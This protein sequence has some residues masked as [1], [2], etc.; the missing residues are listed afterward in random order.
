VPIEVVQMILGHSS[1]EI[2]RRIYAHVMRKAT[3]R[4]V[5]AATE[6]LARHHRQEL[7]AQACSAAVTDRFVV[8]AD[9]DDEEGSGPCCDDDE[10]ADVDEDATPDN[11]V[12]E[13]ATPDNDVD[14][15]EDA[16][17]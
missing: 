11:D 8:D 14:E 17:G 7:A 6:E 9:P 12:D 3:A 5:E 1:P 15:D 13:D 16:V 4:Q 10:R 2:T